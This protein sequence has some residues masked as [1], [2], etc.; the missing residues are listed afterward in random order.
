M[1]SYA[2]TTATV[3]VR[4]V[5]KPHAPD[6]C[7][8]ECLLCGIAAYAEHSLVTWAVKHSEQCPQLRLA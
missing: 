1:E 7:A 4:P 5:P 2:P 6:A 3:S 8:A